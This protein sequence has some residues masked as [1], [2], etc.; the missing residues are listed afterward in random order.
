SDRNVF[1]RA[2]FFGFHA[3]EQFNGRFPVDGQRVGAREQVQVRVA[4]VGAGVR[5][6]G[7]K[8]IDGEGRAVNGLQHVRAPG[9]ERVGEAVGELQVFDGGIAV[10]AD[11]EGEQ[12]VVTSVT[13]RGHFG[14]LGEADG[15]VFEGEGRGRV[16]V[17]R[18]TVAVVGRVLTAAAVGVIAVDGFVYD[19]FFAARVESAGGGVVEEVRA[20]IFRRCAQAHGDRGAVSAFTDCSVG[21]RVE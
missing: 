10:V 5:R 16:V 2:G 15:R 19:S 18:V 11:G 6:V 9:A 21:G 8:R 17:G 1:V 4:V 13:D 3:D 12:H 14:C 20:R 7:R